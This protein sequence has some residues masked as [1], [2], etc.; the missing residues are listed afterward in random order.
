[1]RVQDPKSNTEFWKVQAQHEKAEG[2]WNEMFDELMEF[3][4]KH[5]HCH[6]PKEYS[7]NPV[8]RKIDLQSP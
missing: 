2:L 6:V 1:M 3:K 8:S 5:G 7:E 4:N